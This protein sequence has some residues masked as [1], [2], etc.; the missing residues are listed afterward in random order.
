[1]PKKSSPHA[2]TIM[3]LINN[4]SELSVK[5]HEYALARDVIRATKKVCEEL[6]FEIDKDV[7]DYI[8]GAIGVKPPVAMREEFDH[9]ASMI[10]KMDRALDKKPLA[11]D[12]KNYGKS[13]DRN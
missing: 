12:Y 1:M 2:L 8:L 9:F 4:A 13:T 10:I 6:G 3:R 5:H 11:S 7:F